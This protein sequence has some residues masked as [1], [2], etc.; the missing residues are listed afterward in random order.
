MEFAD[1]G[2]L[3]SNVGYPIAMTVVLCLYV[4][5]LQS[6]N[7]EMMTGFM[8]TLEEYNLKLERL[9]HQIDSLIN[10]NISGGNKP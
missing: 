1:F 10:N 2:T 4:K 7:K 3:I 8:H 9:A 6:D 5:K